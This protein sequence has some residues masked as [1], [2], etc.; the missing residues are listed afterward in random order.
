MGNRKEE[1]GQG[2]KDSRVQ[3]KKLQKQIYTGNTFI[4]G[5]AFL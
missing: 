5:G 3:V 1:R 4:F 2:F